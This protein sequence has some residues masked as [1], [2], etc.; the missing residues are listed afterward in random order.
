MVSNGLAAKAHRYVSGIRASDVDVDD[1]VGVREC[2]ESFVRCADA[3][4]TDDSVL[5]NPD[6]LQPDV[7][8]SLF[9]PSRG[10]FRL[11]DPECP[12]VNA[13]PGARLFQPA[14]GGFG[15]R[16]SDSELLCV[17]PLD[18]SSESAPSKRSCH[19]R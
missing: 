15:S 2:R 13:E 5:W 9:Y 10:G 7:Q 6:C 19:A 14:P 3:R 4:Q 18:G 16:H 8:S 17:G 11:G 1:V 12:R